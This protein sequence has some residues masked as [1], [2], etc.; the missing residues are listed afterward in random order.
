MKYGENIMITSIR[1][2]FLTFLLGPLWL[3][4]LLLLFPRDAKADVIPQTGLCA[5]LGGGCVDPHYT[6]VPP[7]TFA[8]LP[9]TSQT[10]STTAPGFL[11]V[12]AGPSGAFWIAPTG[13]SGCCLAGSVFDYR[14]SFSV[15]TG[16]SAATVSGTLATLGSAAAAVNG[17]GTFL[18]PQ[19]LTAL[20]PF[21]F[22]VSVNPGAN[23]LDFIVNGCVSFPSCGGAFEPVSALLVDPSWMPAAPGA[24]LVTTPESVL[25]ADGGVAPSSTPEPPA[26][27]LL[28]SGL[29]SLAL[30][31]RRR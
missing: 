24:T 9:L 13:D 15:P 1:P 16:V 18:G 3:I 28:G 23:F 20:T 31:L 29:M 12:P 7:S 26:L 17:L 6:L 10:F 19:S 5:P 4:G 21:S 25:F 8:G 30:F 2:R 22:S 14:V 27:V 11:P